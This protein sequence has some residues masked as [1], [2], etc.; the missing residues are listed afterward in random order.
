[1]QLP[2][3]LDQNV[4]LIHSLDVVFQRSDFDTLLSLVVYLRA[5]FDAQIDRMVDK[6][7]RHSSGVYPATF[8]FRRHWEAT[9]KKF[10]RLRAAVNHLQKWKR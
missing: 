7:K 6:F 3:Q 4:P 9:F 5:Q 8:G 1:M 10:G 2:R